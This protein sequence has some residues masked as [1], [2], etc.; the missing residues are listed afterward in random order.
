VASLKLGTG[1]FIA[2]FDE[3]DEGTVIAKAAKNQAGIPSNQWFLT[4]DADGTSLSSD[5]YLRLAAEAAKMIKGTRPLTEEVPVSH[6]NYKVHVN[7]G[8][9]AILGRNAD[10]DGLKAYV[11]F[12]ESGGTILEFCQK[13]ADSEE[14]KN[15]SKHIPPED[16]AER[17]YQQI[18]KRPSDP[19]GLEG[20]TNAIK[21][22][23]IARRAA[24][25]LGS[26]EFFEKFV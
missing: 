12:L 11:E 14:F 6:L 8:Y 26:R 10:P 24:D 16:L 15:N 23:Q 21:E 20:T 25:M 3:F 5:F 17:L 19:E 18:L 2:M 13:L 22:G 1:A 9:R 4:L 7:H